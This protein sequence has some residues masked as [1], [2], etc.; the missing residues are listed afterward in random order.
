MESSQIVSFILTVI[1]LLGSWKVF[2]KMGLEGWRG[3]I[4]IY[5]T[6]LLFKELYGNG[7][8]MFLL[9]IP[10]YNIYVVIKLNI[11][12]TKAFDMPKAFAAGLILMNNVFMLI[13]GYNSAI[14]TKNPEVVE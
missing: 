9:L 3:I 1:G 2:E 8:K 14:Y 7:W 5:N 12:L 10:F 6:Y 4:P 11:D 13:L